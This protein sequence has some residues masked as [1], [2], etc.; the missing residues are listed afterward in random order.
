M[1]PVSKSI[2]TQNQDKAL[3]SGVAKCPKLVVGI[4]IAD[5]SARLTQSI[6]ALF[7]DRSAP[8]RRE[9]RAVDTSGVDAGEEERCKD[10]PTWKLFG[11]N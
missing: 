9:S 3:A 11:R 5:Y 10:V 2:T 6:G 8:K 7:A 4:S 1:P